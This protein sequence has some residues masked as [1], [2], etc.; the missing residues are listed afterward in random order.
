MNFRSIAGILAVFLG[1]LFLPALTTRAAGPQLSLEQIL[2]RLEKHYTGSAFSAAFVQESAIKAM[3]LTDYASG[4]V[5]V[6]YPGKMRWEYDRPDRQ[7]IVTDG[8]KLWIYRPDDRQVMIGSAPAFF[9]D[10]AGASFLSDI[11]LIR[12]KF[13][14]SLENQPD[15]LLY[16]LKLVPRKETPEVAA[17]HL[18]VSR[19][20]FTIYRVVTINIYGDETRIELLNLK[21]HQALDDAL[22]RF[23]IP[24]GVEVLRMDE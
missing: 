1:M 15:D 19:K 12:K 8:A 3:G 17:V 22:F 14:I 2:D 18:S 11:K 20:T 5:Y 10:G 7:V 16:R 6:Q 4:K 24:K 21:A 23:Q 13:E 9:R